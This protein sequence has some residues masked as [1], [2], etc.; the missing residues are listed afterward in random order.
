MLGQLQDVGNATTLAHYL[1][2]LQRRRGDAHRA[3]RSMARGGNSMRQRG[4]S[5]KLQVM[6]TALMTAQSGLSPD[7]ARADREFRGRLVES[8][9]GRASRQRGGGRTYVCEPALLAR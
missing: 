9:G 4:S 8:A 6:N 2:L 5:P 1:E 7:E 3:S